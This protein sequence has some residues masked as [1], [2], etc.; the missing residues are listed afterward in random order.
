MMRLALV[1]SKG[2]CFGCLKRGHQSKNCRNRLNCE[3]CGKQHPTPLHDPTYNEGSSNQN[4]PESTRSDT[5]QSHQASSEVANDVSTNSNPNVSV[6]SAVSGHGVVTNSLIIPVY[7]YRKSHPELKVKVYTLLDDASDTTF[8]KTDVKDK[9]G[10]P[11]VDSKLI[12]RTMLGSEEI[13]VSRV[14]GLVVEKIDQ[15]VQVE[16]P[17]TYSRDQIPSR[18]D[19]IPSPEVAAVWPHLQKIKDK[20]MPYQES[21]EIG[22]L[23]GCNCPK[24]IKPKEVILGKGEDPYAV[25][26]LL[27]WGIIG[28]VSPLEDIQPD[29][30]E[31]LAS[32][33]NRILAYE[34]DTG[35]C[36]NRS[37]VLN[38]QTKE[39]INPFAVRRMFERDFS[40]ESTS[41]S[42]L[43]KEDRRFLAI[44]SGGITQLENGHYELPLPLKNPN[45]VLPNNRESAFRRL[46]QLKRR[47]LADG[48]YRDDYV[49][50]METMIEKGFAERVKPGA[51]S[52]PDT[53]QR[54]VWYIPHH[55]VYHPKK[56]TKIRVVFDCA[57]EFKGESLNKHLLQGPNLTNT[58][59]GVLNRF[60]QEH[61]GLM[62]DIES[63][64]YQVY[65]AE[66]YRD[67]L[68]FLWWENG[69]HSK[70]PVEYRMTVHLFGATSSPGCANFALKKTV[71]DSECELG[72]AAADFLRNDFYVD[73]GLKSCATIE[74]TN[75][76]IKSVKEMCRRGGFN[77]QK[78]VSNKK[79]V[80][81]NIPMIDRADDLK[82]INLDL[83]KVPMER[84]VGVQWCIQ[85]DTF[86][87]RIALKD[88]PCTRRGI[89]STV[90]SNFDP[91][92][93]IAP[94]LLE[95]KSILQD[96]CR[97]GVDWDDPIIPDVIR[98]R[99]ERWRTELHV[100]QHF[101]IPRCFKPDDFGAVVKKELHH[102]SD[103]STKGYGQCSYLR[104]Q[105]DSGRIH[106]AFV[107]GKSRV[108]P[109]KPVTIPRLEL[110]AAVISVKI[111]QQIRQELSLDDVQEF[112]WSD[113]KVVLGYIANESRRFHVF[114][115]NRVQ[116]IQDSTSVDQWKYV[117]TKLN[118][119]DDASRGLSPIALVTSRWSTGPVF[120]W[121][122]ENE[123][124]V[125][126]KVFP[127]PSQ[128]LPCDPEVK[129]VT[130]L[131]TKSMKRELKISDRLE[132]FSDWFRAR[133]AIALSLL[134][135]QRL[136]EQ[137]VA[138]HKVSNKK[139]ILEV[140]HLQEAENVI[141]KSV[142]STAFPEELKSL[143]SSQHV[144]SLD[145]RLATP[146][147]RTLC[148]KQSSLHK[149]DPFLDSQGILRVGGRLR[150]ASLPFEIKVL[151]I[152]PRSSHVTTLII[153]YFHEKIKHQG[154]GMTLNEIRANG[155]WIVG[156]TSAVG[157]YIWSCVVCRKMRSAVIE[158]K[159]ADLPEDRVEPAP[160][161]SF[162]AVDYFGPFSIKEGRKQMKRYGVLFTCLA[163]RAVHLET[164]T[165]LETDAFINALRRF[166]CRR[167]PVRQLRSDQG[168][169]FVG[170][171]HELKAA[172]AELDHERIKAELLQENCDWFTFAMNV[173]SSSHMGGVWERQ[174][175]TVRSVLSP[176]LESNGLQLDD[177]SLR[178]FMCEVE[179]IINTCP[180]TVDL[181]NDPGS[182]SPLTPN[183]LLTMKTR[184][185]LS[186]PGVFT[187]ADKFCRKRWR[188]V[189]HL[190]N[191]FWSRWRKEYL[192]SLQ[193][194]QKWTVSRNDVGVD[195]IVI[196]KDDNSPRSHWQL[197]RICAVNRSSDGRVR[198]VKLL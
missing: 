15:R 156:G 140:Q 154:R 5:A 195:D 20:I 58:L 22:L 149:L 77:L 161:F 173:P 99:W 120:L 182:L 136:R 51:S 177:E 79:E 12:L 6:C 35:R 61:V 94:V 80:L 145:N 118:P 8:I 21:L 70:D 100:L 123:W 96:L 74:E 188:R 24:A 10:I 171:K 19:Q 162:C 126:E 109:L 97:N 192:L 127:D 163:S 144:K 172:L 67:L 49:T 95:G 125:D 65:V 167:G 131:A 132:Y 2:L 106:C 165:S 48:R 142:Q 194:R 179:A 75:H 135:L 189:Q 187:S 134:Y 104:L 23:I 87:F 160:P 53:E 73:D 112:F 46:L 84:A 91:L 183:H 152:L 31:H 170:A 4:T 72:P 128:V 62:C 119:A 114:V 153:R 60:R 13:A 39:E 54:N 28:P 45:V 83:D 185:V 27:G 139:A 76:L 169:N 151:V 90:S 71:Q 3:K 121:Q 147:E 196:I 92:G 47:F 25:R 42:G 110:Q 88:R 11:G 85:S 36:S 108:T 63:M 150:N 111:S 198:T 69:D 117:E 50:F 89:L 141:V 41:G 193:Q 190:A 86:Q 93:F 38:S 116:L 55:G 122:K 26:T 176:L 101:S 29:C 78:F 103:A 57:T 124:P 191:E 66:E 130:V 33:C 166:I 180:L 18:R 175:R 40:E 137:V 43:S 32:S 98:A 168:T 178:T 174:I 184:V 102:F 148:P 56:P 143:K 146:A 7:V 34:V 82:N 105:D 81:K 113:S 133:R 157:S 197:A 164:S 129:K 155:Y 52:S 115:A 159:M 1:R 158:Q 186:P 64:F 30:E 138:E 37:F 68:R 9:L 17:R 44:A 16:L 181:L 107:A 59:T 14:E